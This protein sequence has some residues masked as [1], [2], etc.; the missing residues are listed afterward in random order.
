MDAAVAI[1]AA[2]ANLIADLLYAAFN[3]R[4]LYW[5]IANPA[6]E[7]DVPPG[8]TPPFDRVGR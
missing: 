3:P 8:Q 5:Q 4:M 6:E 7:V 2:L 1:S